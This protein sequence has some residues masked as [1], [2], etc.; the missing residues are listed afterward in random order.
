MATTSVPFPSIRRPERPVRRPQLASASHAGFAEV[1]FIKRIDNSRLQ[2]E[3][4]PARRR[5]CFTLLSLGGVVFAAF[6][7]LAWQHFQ[8]VHFGYQIQQLKSQQSALVEMNRELR[9]EQA[10]LA[11]PQ[12]IDQL[13][14]KRLGLAPPAPQQ[15][16]RLGPSGAP[17]GATVAARSRASKAPRGR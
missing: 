2:R 9:L 3:V 13:A 6:L 12:R 15:I 16:V 17:A 4:N 10:S 5:Q 14:R 7:M 1:Y 11:D 8:C